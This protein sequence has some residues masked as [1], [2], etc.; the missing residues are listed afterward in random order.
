MNDECQIISS[1]DG[2]LLLLY[3]SISSPITDIEE[4]VTD[5]GDAVQTNK[6]DWMEDKVL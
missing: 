1:L 6:E 5:T 4:C 2:N 3:N